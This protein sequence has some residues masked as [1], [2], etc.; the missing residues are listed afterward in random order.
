MK[1][2]NSEDEVTSDII[3]DSASLLAKIYKFSETIARSAKQGDHI[4]NKVFLSQLH[5][6]VLVEEVQYCL[7]IM[8]DFQSQKLLNLIMGQHLIHKEVSTVILTCKNKI[9][10]ELKRL[11]SLRIFLGGGGGESEFYRDTIEATHSAFGHENS[12]IPLYDVQNVPFPMDFDMS[13][14][15][16][17]SFHRFT[18]A[19]GLSIPDYQAPEVIGFP[20]QFLDAPPPPPFIRPERETGYHPDDNTSN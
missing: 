11:P 3:N 12:G 6:R 17:N 13:E 16:T 19:Y 5:L 7:E 2:P 20:K 10:D 9:P 1:L 8:K 14:L 18:I 4:A 15:N